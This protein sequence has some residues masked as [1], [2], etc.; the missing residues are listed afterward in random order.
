M[1]EAINCLEYRFLE[2]L[3]TIEALK[4]KVKTLKEGIEVGGSAHLT[5]KG[6][7]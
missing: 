6:S 7:P 5:G 3:D 1:K 4:N 2:S